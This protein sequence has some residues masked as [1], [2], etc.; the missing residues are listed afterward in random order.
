MHEFVF[1]VQHTFAIHMRL[2]CSYEHIHLCIHSIM[3]NIN[4]GPVTKSFHH[5][6]TM[7]YNNLSLEEPM[8]VDKMFFFFQYA[9]TVQGIYH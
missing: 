2:L 9:G 8:A 3:C 4:L 1:A 5:S 7:A 6:Q